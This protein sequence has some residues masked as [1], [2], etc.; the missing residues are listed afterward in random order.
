MNNINTSRA[1]YIVVFISVITFFCAYLIL[2]P[3]EVNIYFIFESISYGVSV[4]AVII[5]VFRKWLW[6]LAIFRKWLVLIPDI[7]GIWS[8]Y[9]TPSN[10]NRKKSIDVKVTFKQSLFNISCVL[11]TE[12][13]K[14]ECITCVF[15]TSNNSQTQQLIYNYMNT[16]RLTYRKTSPMHYGSTILDIE[17]GKLS[18]NYWTDRETTGFMELTKLSKNH[19]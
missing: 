3:N 15:F 7:N 14:S 17:D 5:L 6:K 12:E 4:N 18:G 2:K 1:L 16:P 9:L 10:S 19:E 13:S 8:G 11:E